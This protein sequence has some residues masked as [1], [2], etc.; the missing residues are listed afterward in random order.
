MSNKDPY[1]E[2]DYAYQ[3]LKT[4]AVTHNYNKWIVNLFKPYVGKNVLEIGCGIGNLTRYLRELGQISCL[5]ES[6]YFLQHIKIDYPGLN[7][8]H[9]DIADKKVCERKS[10]H[11]DTIVCVNVLEHIENDEQSLINMHDILEI[12]GRVLIFV[13]AMSKLFNILDERLG[14]FRR[15]D[16]TGLENKLQQTG[17]IVEEIRYSNLI[18]M[19]GW[20]LR[21]KFSPQ[22]TF[23]VVSTILFDKLVVLWKVGKFINLP[24][25]MSLFAVARKG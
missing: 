17:F 15:Y 10:H 9:Y 22:G 5:D 12:G 21:G 4:F 1:N 16:K 14:H 25:G 13:P 23:P 18:G 2:L 7:F 24:C 6:E 8:Y 11:F 19:I 20:F 3:V